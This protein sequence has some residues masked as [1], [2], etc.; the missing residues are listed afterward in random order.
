MTRPNPLPSL[1]EGAAV[2]LV[3]SITGAALLALAPRGAGGAGAGGLTAAALGLSY[4]GYLLSRSPASAGRVSA[5][6][7]AITATGV[8]WLMGA[9]AQEMVLLQAV[10]IWLGR[11]LFFHPRPLA[12]LADGALLA[13]GSVI[14]FW[15]ALRTGSPLLSLWTLFLIQSLFVL[16]PGA[17]ARTTVPSSAFDHARRRAERALTRLEQTR[18]R[19]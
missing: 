6:L 15:A 2:A 13:M 8:L 19:A 9:T 14:A 4:L 17:P 16:I 1:L 10:L 11:S 7:A 5:V 18:S 12:A 3:L